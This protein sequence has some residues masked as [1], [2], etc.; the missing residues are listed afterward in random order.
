MRAIAT[1]PK[2]VSERCATASFKLH[3]A[4][5]QGR[6]TLA[7]ALGARG[8]DAP[9]VILCV[10]MPFRYLIPCGYRIEVP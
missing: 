5:E 6:A 9:A 1:I 2:C 8:S 7:L 3:R 10:A 4:L